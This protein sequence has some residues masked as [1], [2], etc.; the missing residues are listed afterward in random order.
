MSY[1]S[2]DHD[3]AEAIYQSLQALGETIYDRIKIFL[4]SKS[5]EGG[6]EIRADIKAGLKKSDFLVVERRRQSL[7]RSRYFERDVEE[8]EG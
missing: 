5:I 7:E 3:I 8:G 2:E 4:D 6:D 1:A